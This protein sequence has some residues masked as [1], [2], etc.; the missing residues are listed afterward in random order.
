VEFLLAFRLC[1]TPRQ[2]E[3]TLF[4]LHSPFYTYKFRLP[5]V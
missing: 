2:G 5:S 3:W 4:A 1:E